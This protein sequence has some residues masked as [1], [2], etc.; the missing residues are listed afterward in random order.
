MPAHFFYLL[1]NPDTILLRSVVLIEHLFP[2]RNPM[3]FTTKRCLLLSVVA[4]FRIITADTVSVS[5]EIEFP[6]RDSLFIAS[7]IDA[8]TK[9]E[10]N[11]P[12]SENEH[13]ITNCSNCPQIYQ[14][15]IR[16][17][18]IV[19][20][21]AYYCGFDY[22]SVRFTQSFTG[23]TFRSS[24]VV[25]THSTEPDDSL[26]IDSVITTLSD[27]R[28]VNTTTSYLPTYKHKS[29]LPLPSI[30][31]MQNAPLRSIDRVAAA[32]SGFQA[33]CTISSK[34]TPTWSFTLQQRQYSIYEGELHCNPSASTAAS[35][36]SP[37]VAYRLETWGT[38]S[39]TP[40]MHA[41]EHST[42]PRLQ[43]LSVNDSQS[44]ILAD[45]FA[46]SNYGLSSCIVSSGSNNDTIHLSSTPTWKNRISVNALPEDSLLTIVITDIHGNNA[47]RFCSIF[48]RQHERTIA[49]KEQ[50]AIELYAKESAQHD[51][52]RYGTWLLGRFSGNPISYFA[53]K[54]LNNAAEKRIAATRD[55]ATPPPSDTL[56]FPVIGS[57]HTSR[58]KST[59]G[60]YSIPLF[61]DTICYNGT[62]I[63]R[64]VNPSRRQTP[65]NRPFVNVSLQA[66]F[67]PGKHPLSWKIDSLITS[68]HEKQS[69][70][71]LL[72][73][74]VSTQ[75]HTITLHNIPHLLDN[76]SRKAE[77]TLCHLTD[78]LQEDT[79]TITYRIRYTD[80]TSAVLYQQYRIDSPGTIT[81]TMRQPYEI[82]TVPSIHLGMSGEADIILHVTLRGEKGIFRIDA[83]MHSL[84][85]NRITG[86]GAT[87]LPG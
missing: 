58:F 81:P 52:I 53:K 80:N 82:T 34:G 27:D 64:I 19:Y 63:S 84:R 48:T 2:F 5:G 35:S 37:D 41:R 46:T 14:N 13:F 25:Y 68:Y 32:A 77:F 51:P 55:F 54:A 76:I 38:T 85:E 18:E 75:K 10:A 9:L 67:T 73:A 62:Q 69:P 45:I 16:S 4:L 60:N 30:Y 29:H 28:S 86:W 6:D 59:A 49:R 12:P 40:S 71:M 36:V 7:R 15:W 23:D 66:P 47:R 83:F 31:Q 72:C 33:Y 1:K 26:I 87:S 50:R 65:F 24:I 70:V 11:P 21:A 57:F 20:R 78:S 44:I 8:W 17:E 79:L 22:L 3:L 74:S 56:V 42:P 43:L 61:A 39:C